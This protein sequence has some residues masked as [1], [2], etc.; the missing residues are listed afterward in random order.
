MAS[1]T[2]RTRKTAWPMVGLALLLLA[3]TACSG[4]RTST[5]SAGKGEGAASVQNKAISIGISRAPGS[6]TPFDRADFSQLNIASLLFN[7]LMEMDDNLTFVSSL[8]DSIETKDNQTFIAKLNPKAKW[9]D[10]KPVTADDVLFSL[11]MITHPKASSFFA[12]QFSLLEGLDNQGKITSGGFQDFPGAKKIDD[13]TIQFH[14]KVPVDTMTFHEKVSINL[15]ASPKHILKDADP[16][17]LQQ[18]PFLQNPNVSYGAFTFVAYQKNQYVELAAYKDYFKGA[19]K[20]NKL[21]FKIMPAEN[22][23][24]QLQS[25]E[26]QMNFPEIGAIPVQD[27][28]RVKNMSNIRVLSGKPLNDKFMGINTKHIPDPKA[29]QALAYA[30][31]RTSLVTNLMKGEGEVSYGPIPPASPFYNKNLNG[32]YPY[33][34]E[35]A[36][37]QLKEAGWDPNRTLQLL[38][39]NGEKL[40]EQ[41]ADIIAQNLK[42]AGISVQVQKMD[43]G[44]AVQKMKKQ[45]FDLFILGNRFKLDPDLTPFYGTGASNNFVLYGNQ[46]MDELLS[47]GLKSTESAE[48]KN[49]YN[50][51]QEIFIRDMPAVPLF[52]DNRL[53]AVNK[54]VIVGEPKD[55]GMLINVH[56]WDIGN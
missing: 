31:N 35:K 8:A 55:V 14:T 37:Q 51:I 32:S 7:P 17:K 29:R 10:G 45:D 28:E 25:G 20:L 2:Q 23:V 40:I 16:E 42:D 33:N 43:A 3:L 26:I 4:G 27:F 41:S 36:K 6:F 5:E 49:I 54:K 52:L 30:I 9:S 24:V 56:E 12:S 53:R 34:P 46:E 21:F 48:R 18:N 38:V 15:K 1:F 22:I 50:K 44:A 47:K 39:F 19:P 13:H 11:E